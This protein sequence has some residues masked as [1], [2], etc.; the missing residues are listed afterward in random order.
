MNRFFH[1]VLVCLLWAI[2]NG[3]KFPLNSS[4]LRSLVRTRPVAKL[5]Q[6]PSLF[7]KKKTVI[8]S[9]LNDPIGEYESDM[10]DNYRMLFVLSEEITSDQHVVEFIYFWA[11]YQTDFEHEVNVCYFLRTILS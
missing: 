5:S 8:L 7:L 6:Q 9:L 10:D 11:K 2:C 4:P 3:W 1:V